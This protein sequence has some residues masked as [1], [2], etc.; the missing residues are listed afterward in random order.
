MAKDIL[1]NLISQAI[2]VVVLS[3]FVA[4]VVAWG[5]ILGGR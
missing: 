3:L 1:S 4:A 2:I 5:A